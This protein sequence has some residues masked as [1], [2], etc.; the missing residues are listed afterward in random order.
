MMLKTTEELHMMRQN[1]AQRK[2]MEDNVEYEEK[3]EEDYDDDDDI[4]EGLV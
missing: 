1:E 3:D 2:V 4:I